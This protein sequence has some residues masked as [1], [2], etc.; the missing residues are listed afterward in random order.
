MMA[1]NYPFKKD[2][3]AAI[4]QPLRYTET[5]LFGAEYRANGTFVAVGP[6]PYKRKWFAEITMKGGLIDKVS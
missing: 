4:G 5:S 2:L 1:A 6:S 3:K